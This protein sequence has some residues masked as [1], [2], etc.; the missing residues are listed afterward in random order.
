M[1]R[2]RGRLTVLSVLLAS[3]IVVL[4]G[5]TVQLQAGDAVAAARAEQ[6]S[7]VRT[8]IDPAVRGV[9]LDQAGRPL[10]ANREMLQVVADRET[11]YALPQ[12]GAE[13]LDRTAQVL[14]TTFADLDARLTLCQSESAVPGTC[15]DGAPADPIPLASDV[16]META[17]PI[18]EQAQDYPG[19]A[20]R[21]VSVRGYPATAGER[22]GQLLGHLGAA[23]E[24]EVAQGARANDVFGRGG[25]E[26]QYDDV[27]RGEPGSRTVLLDTAGAVSQTLEQSPPANGATLVT[28]LDA[29]LQAVVEQQLAAAVERARAAGQNLAGDSGAA[30]VVDVTDG[31]ILALASYPDYAP[32][33]F[34]GGIS[35]ADY[36]ALSDSGALLFNPVQGLYAPGSTF[37]PFTVAG[38]VQAGFSLDAAYAC[39]GAYTAGGRSFANHESKAYGTISLARALEVS[40]NTVFYRAADE[41]W[42][43]TGGQDAPAQTTDPINAAAA[44]FGLG[45]AT[46]IDLPGEA[47]GTLDGRAEKAR[48]WQQS[49]DKWCAAAAAGYPELRQTDPALADQYTAL[50]RDNC[51]SGGLWRQGDALNAAIGQGLTAVT[52]LQIA[53]AYAAIANGGTR[54]QPQL[55]K[56][57]VKPDGTVQT[58]DPKVTGT[59][60]APPATLRFLTEAMVG[61]TRQGTAASAFRGFPLDQIPVAGK[62]GSAQV[63]GG[64]PATSWFASFAPAAAPR[65]AVVMM[66]TQ[67][68]TGAETSAPSVRAIYEALFG[69][70]DGV[71]DPS[72]SVLVGGQPTLGLPPLPGT[73]AAA[74]EQDAP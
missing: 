51:D 59:L 64:R 7:R 63:S 33:V 24:Q 28:S 55:G 39:P 72:R 48:L 6:G 32:T 42:R 45:S 73:P 18:L 23:T 14:R 54:Y 60:A 11:L 10:A 3:L 13:V 70:V 71:P 35:E 36:R 1:R 66:V 74:D 65:Y 17:L 34:D 21:T 38:M 9:I 15:W 40:C 57:V 22:A 26:Q 12:D 61:V 62:T 67:G 41:I 58:L 37:K 50:D 27:L 2:S 19:I 31:R 20:V 16:G 29:S 43:A 30:V 49:K 53:M 8:L 25:L 4:L 44:D 47:A 5:R 46:G 68:G 69:V 56:A 52:P